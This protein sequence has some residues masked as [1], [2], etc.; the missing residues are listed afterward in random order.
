MLWPVARPDAMLWPEAWREA[1]L[2][3]ESLREAMLHLT[4]SMDEGVHAPSEILSPSEV[5]ATVGCDASALTPLTVS[6][7]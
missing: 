2:R 4:I 7:I 3:L 1:M 5:L 6:N